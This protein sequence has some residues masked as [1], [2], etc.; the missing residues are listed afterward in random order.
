MSPSATPA[1]QKR[2]GATGDQ[3][4]LKA[5]TRASPARR[6]QK[7]VTSCVCDN[8]VCERVVCD[9]NV[10]CERVVCDNVVCERVVCVCV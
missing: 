10:V 7:Y 3:R 5:A 1:T 8:V 6:T 4:R 2:R 9:N